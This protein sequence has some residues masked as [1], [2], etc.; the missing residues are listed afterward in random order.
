MR[1][2]SKKD[3]P[4]IRKVFFLAMMDGYVNKNVKK[5]KLTRLPGSRLITFEHNENDLNF[6]VN[7]LYFVRK[8]SEF[9]SGI[10]TISLDGEP[11]WIMNYGG[12]YHKTVISFLKESLKHSYALGYFKGGRGPSFYRESNLSY[13]N[14]CTGSFRLF[15]GEEKI[16]SNVTGKVLGYHK[17][18]GNLMV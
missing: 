4:L 3:I 11:V 13:Y 5:G 1:A 7:D 8:S 16:V 10:T 18:F 6:C 14:N 9:S 17:Y 15:S 12:K 2:L